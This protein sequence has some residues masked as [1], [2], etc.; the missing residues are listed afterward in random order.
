MKNIQ[1][2]MTAIVFL[3]TLILLP[4]MTIFSGKES[5]SSVEN[6]TLQKK[7][8]LSAESWFDKSF[9]KDFEGD[10]PGAAARDC[11]NYLDMNLNMAKYVAAKYYHEVLENI[12]KERLYYSES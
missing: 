11:G 5:F 9:M 6:R 10:V 8:S 7:P 4:V 2:R 3:L 12:T 1:K